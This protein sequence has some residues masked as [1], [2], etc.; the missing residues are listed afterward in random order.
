VIISDSLDDRWESL[1]FLEAF[2]HLLHASILCS[3]AFLWSPSNN[4]L[5]YAYSDELVQDEAEA[6][7][8]DETEDG[9]ERGGS[10]K[11]AAAVGRRE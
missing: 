8:Q 2:W 5:Q 10:A 7:G 3:V 11:A 9:D 4:N 6:D 1:W